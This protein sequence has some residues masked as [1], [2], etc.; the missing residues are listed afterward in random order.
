MSAPK[1]SLLYERYELKYHIPLALVD[2]ISDYISGFC[3][4]DHYSKQSPDQYYTINNLYLDTPTYLFFRTRMS[5]VDD[6]FNMRV[7]TYGDEESP[8]WFLEIKHKSKGFVRKTRAKLT[9]TQWTEHLANGTLPLSE[10]VKTRDY[11]YDFAHKVMSYQAAPVV[12]TQYRRKAY[13]STIDDYARVT[14]DKEMRFAPRHSYSFEREGLIAYDNP[15]C[16]D[17]FTNVILELKCESRVPWWMVDLIRRFNLERSTFSKFI[18]A[19]NETMQDK[20]DI[21]REYDRVPV[22]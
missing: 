10:G 18:F 7:R 19:V 11:A 6:R 17:P 22:N 13:F 21:R 8:L 4:L 12:F 20:L 5:G 16:F 14:F 3:E 2:E 15:N 1:S 9:D